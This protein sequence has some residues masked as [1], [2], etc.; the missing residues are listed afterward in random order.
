[1]SKSWVGWR[2][3]GKIDGFGSIT[4]ISP[5]GGGAIVN[6][7]GGGIVGLGGG[8]IISAHFSYLNT[9]KFIVSKNS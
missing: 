4:I 7:G 5:G 1:M 9:R 2:W 8:A 3:G 6:L